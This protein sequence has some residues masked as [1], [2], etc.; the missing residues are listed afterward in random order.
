MD[1]HGTTHEGGRSHGE[2]GRAMKAAQD[3]GRTPA[4]GRDVEGRASIGKAG[5][6]PHGD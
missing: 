4:C 2:G 5:I 6:A 1:V 3:N